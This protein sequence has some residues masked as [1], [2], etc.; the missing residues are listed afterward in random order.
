VGHDPREAPEHRVVLEEV[1]AHLRPGPHRVDRHHLEV[2]RRA[3]H[4][5][6]DLA[7]DPAEP[8]D[9]DADLRSLHGGD[10]RPAADGCPPPQAGLNVSA[11]ADSSRIRAKAWRKSAMMSSN[12]SSSK[13][14]R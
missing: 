13:V 8:V 12:G 14:P 6:Y 9:G 5:A 3:G 4:L 10:G 2:R 1:G 11:G 7:A